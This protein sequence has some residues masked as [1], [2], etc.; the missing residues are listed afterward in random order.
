M[1]I[2]VRYPN[3]R[4]GCDFLCFLFMNYLMSFRILY[5]KI[6]MNLESCRG[7]HQVSISQKCPSDKGSYKE[8]VALYGKVV[9]HQ[10]QVSSFISSTWCYL[11]SAVVVLWLLSFAGSQFW[12]AGKTL[13]VLAEEEYFKEDKNSTEN[14]VKVIFYFSVNYK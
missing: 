13:N 9:L 2:S 5:S 12:E 14:S 10:C 1:V 3:H 7:Q 6:C 8:R 11:S 4:H